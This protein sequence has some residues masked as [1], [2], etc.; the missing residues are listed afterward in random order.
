MET[1]PLWF[2]IIAFFVI[3]SISI[4]IILFCIYII[5]SIIYEFIRQLTKYILL[6]NKTY[7]IQTKT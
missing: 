2:R 4:G 7:A 5:F 6:I 1:T 3:G